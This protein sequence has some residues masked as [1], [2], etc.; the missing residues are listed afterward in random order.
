[1]LGRGD[2]QLVR[3]KIACQRFRRIE[4]AEVLAY[5][6]MSFISLDQSRAAVPRNNPA[7]RVEQ[8]DGVVLDAF[9][10]ETKALLALSKRFMRLRCLRHVDWLAGT[11]EASSP[12]NQDSS[13]MDQDFLS[14][15]GVP[16]SDN[17]SARSAAAAPG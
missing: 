9:H 16:G 2:A 12:W 3:W 15:T 7:F 4:L 5:N 17:P 1:T 8:E 11:P 13:A 6:F 10:Q 14:A